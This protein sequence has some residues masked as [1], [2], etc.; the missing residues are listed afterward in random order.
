[1]SKNKVKQKK[2]SA[3][4]RKSLGVERPQINSQIKKTEKTELDIKIDESNDNNF[5][6]AESSY[7]CWN[8]F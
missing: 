4:Q 1:M 5:N 6:K 7:Y 2:F 3:R 8:R